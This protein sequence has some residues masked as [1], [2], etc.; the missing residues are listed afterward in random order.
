[1]ARVFRAFS[2]ALLWAVFSIGCDNSTTEPVTTSGDANGAAGQTH[3][4]SPGESSAQPATSMRFAEMT[5]DSGVV[6]TYHNGQ[7][8][9]N[10]SIPESLGGGIAVIDA[11]ADGREDLL[12]PGGGQIDAELKTSG[13]PCGLFRNRGAGR[14]EDCSAQSGAGVAK[15][16]SHGGAAADFDG[17]GFRDV[18]VTGYG[19]LQLLHNLGDGTFQEIAAPSGLTDS[20]WS[21][22]AAWGDINGDGAPDVYI[23]HYVDWS[24]E[25]HPY[26]QGPTEGQREIC[27]PR[28]FTG[29]PDTLYFSDGSGG[30]TD[31]SR[32]MNL[33]TDG[34][35]LGVVVA[36]VNGDRLLDVYVT[37]DTVPNTLYH[38]T[39]EHTLTD[40]SLLSGSSLS[41]RGVPDGSMGVELMDYN[42]D[43]LFDLWVT[44]YERE[45]SALYENH[46]NMLFR[47]SS[48]RLGVNAVGAL[49]VGWGT[50]AMDADLDGD[51]DLFVS[52]GHVIRFPRSN[53]LKQ[54]PLM[55]E[56]LSGTRLVNVAQAIGGFF[57]ETHM[58][59]GAVAF[60]F[61]DDGD[62]DLAVSHNNDPASIVQN[63][64]DTKHGWLKIGLIG[65]RGAREAIGTVVRVTSTDSDGKQITQSRQWKGGGSYGSTGSRWMHFGLGTAKT[66]DQV[67]IEWP[68]GNDQTYEAVAANA[69]WQAVEGRNALVPAIR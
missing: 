23:C 55:F 5:A 48:Q 65:T 60:D 14:F 20:L 38:S 9:G 11:D 2:L 53:S 69:S 57:A 45:T 6:F 52:N 29:L 37:N 31:E 17:D 64:S 32:A 35:G 39:P 30:F 15:F 7:E 44:N 19:G 4:T 3:G 58:G 51:E 27:P 49:Y 42:R 54:T 13:L 28:D 33:Q 66:A 62:P 46:D 1:M 47:H 40:D 34:K 41:D 50:C 67:Q 18:L 16:Y 68:G 10:F 12:F 36:D 21:S 8:A 59:R 22:S 24:K 63:T 25:N 56:N 61:D 43:G 26:C